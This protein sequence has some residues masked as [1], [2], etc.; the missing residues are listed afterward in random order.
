MRSW[1][2]KRSGASARWSVCL[3]LIG[4][5][6]G[7]V[8][9]KAEVLYENFPMSPRVLK[10]VSFSRYILLESHS[11]MPRGARDLTSLQVRTQRGA[12]CNYLYDFVLT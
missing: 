1:K 11:L 4:R 5:I 8:G 6:Y 10:P 2:D 7:Q 12:Y 9:F 3:S